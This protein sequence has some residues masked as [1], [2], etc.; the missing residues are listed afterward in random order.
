MSIENVV[1]ERRFDGAGG[2]RP[3]LARET[4]DAVR[5]AIE[6]VIHKLGKNGQ[7]HVTVTLEKPAAASDHPE[8]G[9]V[10]GL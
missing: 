9:S 4:G 5:R 2:V 1:Y 8:M 3:D 6:S 10:V 7:I